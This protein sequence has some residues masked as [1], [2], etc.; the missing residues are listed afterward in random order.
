MLRRCPPRLQRV[1]GAAH[2]WPHLYIVRLL[3]ASGEL[4]PQ[5]S[6]LLSACRGGLLGGRQGGGETSFP[7]GC[8]CQH[9]ASPRGAAGPPPTCAVLRAASVTSWLPV[10]DG[11]CGL[12]SFFL[13]GVPFPPAFSSLAWLSSPR[14]GCRGPC[15]SGMGSPA[16][17][18]HVNPL[19]PS[20]GGGSHG[21]GL[22]EGCRGTF[23]RL[24][25]ARAIWPPHL[26]A[27]CS[28]LSLAH[29]LGWRLQPPHLSCVLLKEK[30]KG[31]CLVFQPCPMLASS[32]PAL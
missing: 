17:G 1:A 20:S 31:S 18:G 24:R 13:E 16:C 26:L 9:A 4:L 30:L 15:Q 2:P 5:C 27:A 12:T 11:W 25:S 23:P 10:A 28:T 14:P 19:C 32:S 6:A 21:R 8:R 3:A 22:Q 29:V 7:R